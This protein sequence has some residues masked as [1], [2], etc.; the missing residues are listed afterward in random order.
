MPDNI[1][2]IIFL[3]FADNKVPVFKEVPSKEWILFGEN[4]IF[5]DHLL[6]LYNKSSVHGAIV[7]NKVKYIVG[8]G[9]DATDPKLQKVNRYGESINKVL[10]KF[11]KDIEIFGGG[12]LQVIYDH[13][14]KIKELIHTPFHTIRKGKGGGWW[15]CKHWDWRDYKK[16]DPVFIEDFDLTKPTGV[17]LFSYKEYRPGSEEYPLPG[18]FSSL[19]DI[20]TDTE[21]SIYNLSV[22]KNG[23]F[24]GKLI[25]FFNGEPDEEKKK[26]LEKKWNDKFNGAGNAGKTML[27][28]NE[29]SAK[30]PAVTDLS[31]TDL[32]KLFDQ[33]SKTTQAKIFAGHEVT[34][35]ILFGIQ[36]PGKLGGR[37]EMQDSYEIFKNTYANS[38]QQQLEEVLGV[39]LPL[40][41]LP[42]QKIIPVEPLSTQVVTPTNEAVKNMTGKQY[43]HMDRIIRKYKKGA[44]SKEA[45]AALLKSSFGFTDE[46]IEILLTKDEQFDSY[47]SET[48]IA[49]MFSEIGEKKENFSI[50]KS[51]AFSNED[52]L[53]FVDVKGIDS[54]IVDL[55]RKDKRITS[56]I[57]AEQLRVE[58]SYVD[59]RMK[60]LEERGVLTSVSS[61]IGVDTIIE[62]AVVTESIDTIERPETVDIMLRYSYEPRPGLK[63][64]IETTRPFCRRLIELDRLYSRSEIEQITQRVGFSVW[65]RRGGFWGSHPECRHRWVRHVVIRKK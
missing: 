17:Q 45:A 33:L 47:F 44:S 30:E 59:A 39:F 24:S 60:L 14:G 46:D 7:N 62:R 34:S 4:N 28:F 20:E 1:P 21:I 12:Y 63:P 40:L 27:A 13:V 3:G 11:A 25:S 23:Q 16:I 9:I 22:I 52:Y 2:N 65:D 10:E 49:E 36:E 31:T 55:V 32:D 19:N 42:V 5:P 6:N 53:E 54:S 29:G 26:K 43:Q 57:I 37:N 35:P 8:K 56:E 38:K 64:I 51:R 61:V 15:Y 48:Q 58:K 18:Y 41:G 50:I